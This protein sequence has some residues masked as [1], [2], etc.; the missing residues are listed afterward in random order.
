MDHDDSAPP[1]PVTAR[2]RKTRNERQRYTQRRAE[3]TGR[4]G[5]RQWRRWTISDARIA[6]DPSLSVPDVAIQL[7]R[8]A[9]AVEGLRAKWRAGRLPEALA[10]Q[11]PPP[12]RSAKN[13]RGDH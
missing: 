5:D 3:R 12:P 10:T 13:P 1:Q 9:S 4:T 2:P 11:L 7:G 6:L 8:T